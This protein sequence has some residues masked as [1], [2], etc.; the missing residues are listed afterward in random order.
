MTVVRSFVLP[1]SIAFLNYQIRITMDS[2]RSLTILAVIL[3]LLLLISLYF[4]FSQKGQTEILQQENVET[5]DALD[6]MTSLRDDLASQVDS[7]SQEYQLLA[8]ENEGLE[9]DLSKLKTQLNQA[10]T[11]LAR[12]KRSSAAELND[13]RAQIQELIAVRAGLENSIRSLQ[14]ENDSLRQRTGV[15]ET[16]LAVSTEQNQQLSRLNESIQQEVKRLTLANFKATAFQV[17]VQQGSGERVTARSRRAR[18]ISVSFDLTNVPNEY[19]GVRPIYLVIS[20][21]K[22][23]PVPTDNP[24]RATVRVNGQVTEIIAVEAKD[25]N[26]TDSQRLSFKH[27]LAE[28]LRGGFYRVSVFTDIGILGASSFQLR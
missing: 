8:N 20:D 6:V 27:E 11:A 13:L 7:L 21:D 18:S 4:N 24:V 14:M 12:A 22:G 5:N 19:Q 10:Q 26:I 17:D 2:K 15:L 1:V 16:D 3:G 9:G 28:R 25:I 23:T